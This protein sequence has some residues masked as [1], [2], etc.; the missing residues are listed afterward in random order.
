MRKIILLI[1]FSI[2]TASASFAQRFDDLESARRHRISVSVN[3]PEY[4]G[5]VWTVM[6][7]F[8]Y[9]DYRKTRFNSFSLIYGYRV[10]K[11]LE[12]GLDCRYTYTR[13]TRH[14]TTDDEI[15]YTIHR[16]EYYL[17]VMPTARFVWA[18]FDHVNM[19]SVFGFGVRYKTGHFSDISLTV[20]CKIN[21]LG[22]SVG[23]GKFFGFLELGS[24]TT[25]G[26]GFRF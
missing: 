11:W 3:A 13:Y 17:G 24:V 12:V 18:R 4:K 6:E 2:L 25:I 9:G 10:E 22:I 15:T 7:A 1:V 19:Y 23:G 14:G 5:V 26:A 21:P 20:A 16:P 8:E